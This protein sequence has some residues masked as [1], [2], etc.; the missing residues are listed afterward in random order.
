MEIA[1]MSKNNGKVNYSLYI[2]WNIILLLKIVLMKWG[3]AHAQC[4]MKTR[5]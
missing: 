2:L 4:L 3:N 1:S 5:I